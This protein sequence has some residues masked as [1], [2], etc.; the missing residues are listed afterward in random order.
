MEKPNITKGNWNAKKAHGVAPDGKPMYEIEYTHDGELIAELVYEAADA[1]MMA[2]SKE[3]AQT[4]ADIYMS[5]NSKFR[6]IIKPVLQ[7]AG[8]KFRV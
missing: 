1:Q 6:K 8:Y 2:A 5:S 7:K 4:L 3:M